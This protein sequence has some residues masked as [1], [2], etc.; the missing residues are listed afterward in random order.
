[1]L[2]KSLNKQ[3]LLRYLLPPPSA[4]S[5][6]YNIQRRLHSQLLPQHPGHLMDLNFMAR[7]LYRNIY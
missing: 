2:K 1:M 6:S 3:Y 5:Q 4:T 7:M